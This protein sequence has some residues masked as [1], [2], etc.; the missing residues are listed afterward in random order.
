MVL[1]PAH[2]G[3]HYVPLHDAHHGQVLETHGLVHQII[4]LALIAVLDA[5]AAA[6]G[7]LFLHLGK[8]RRI[9][10]RVLLQIIEQI[11]HPGRDLALGFLGQHHAA[12]GV[13][14]VAVAAAPVGPPADH[15]RHGIV[16]VA[17]GKAGI[18]HPIH[19][20]GL[21]GH[22]KHDLPLAAGGGVAGHSGPARGVHLL[23]GQ[24]DVQPHALAA[25]HGPVLPVLVDHIKIAVVPDLPF[26]VKIAEPRRRLRVLQRAQR[27]A[28]IHQHVPVPLGKHGKRLV[29]LLIQFLRGAGSFRIDLLLDVQQIHRNAPQHRRRHH[30]RQHPPSCRSF[31]VRPR[32]FRLLFHVRAPLP[33]FR[34]CLEEFHTHTISVYKKMAVGSMHDFFK[35]T[36]RFSPSF[37]KHSPVCVSGRAMLQ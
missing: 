21:A 29:H 12:V 22:H 2:P 28:P 13:D 3:V 36:I 30:E 34:R 23:K 27:T 11:L 20:D 14:D 35:K 33:H 19:R 17:D 1:H 24:A 4:A 26:L 25:R 32:F 18:G 5:A 15:L 31:C 16:V 7:H 6:P 37:P 10:L 9:V 8:G